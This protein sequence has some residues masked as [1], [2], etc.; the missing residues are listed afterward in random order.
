MTFILRINMSCLYFCFY[1]VEGMAGYGI[2]LVYVCIL[3]VDELMFQYQNAP[4]GA[5]LDIVRNRFGEIR[6]I[7]A[8]RS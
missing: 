6:F 5:V 4:L 7:F 1:F 2:C 8:C 3:R